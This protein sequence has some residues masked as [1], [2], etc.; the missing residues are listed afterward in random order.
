MTKFEALKVDA[1]LTAS[2]MNAALLSAL[3]SVQKEI[4]AIGEAVDAEVL[5]EAAERLEQAAKDATNIVNNVRS[6]A[7]T[8]S[9]KAYDEVANA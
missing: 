6:T 3:A 4:A 5:L 1:V 8:I 9:R 2:Q 7:R